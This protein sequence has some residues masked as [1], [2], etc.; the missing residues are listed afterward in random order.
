[1]NPLGGGLIPRNPAA[2]FFSAKPAKRESVVSAALRF[3]LSHPAITSALVGFTSTTEID[4][5]V[6]AVDRFSP[7][8]PGRAGAH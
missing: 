5:A 1:M 4:Q 7:V 2:L 8:H 6:A 3:N